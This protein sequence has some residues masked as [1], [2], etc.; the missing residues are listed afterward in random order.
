M[1]GTV[2]RPLLVGAALGLFAWFSQGFPLWNWHH[3]PAG[4]AL[5]EA[6]HQTIGW[7]IAAGAMTL[8]LRRTGAAE[9]PPQGTSGTPR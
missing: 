1:Q 9:D 3:A 6:V 8:V 5:A 7:M 4:F 2:R